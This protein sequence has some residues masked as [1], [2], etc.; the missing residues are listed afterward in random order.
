[1]SAFPKILM[2]AAG[3]LIERSLR[4]RG[5]SARVDGS[6]GKTMADWKRNQRRRKPPEAGIAVPAVSPKGPL[7]KQGGAEAPLTFD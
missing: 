4:Q 7:P 1:M 2:I 6:L 5:K 3:L